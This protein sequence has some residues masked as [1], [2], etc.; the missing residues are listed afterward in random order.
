MLK[1]I[2]E[3]QIVSLDNAREKY[4]RTKKIF[5]ITDMSNMSDIK[6]YIF[7]VSMNNSSFNELL[8]V[9]KKIQKDGY[10]TILIGSY[11]NGGAIGVQYEFS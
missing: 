6:G 4:P 7:A 3:K 11:E 10:Q 2:D 1:M 9:D 5:V 8:E